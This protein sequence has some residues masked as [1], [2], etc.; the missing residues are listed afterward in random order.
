MRILITMYDEKSIEAPSGG[1]VIVLSEDDTI[2]PQYKNLG[3][4]R[5]IH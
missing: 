5:V 4:F 1:I 3:S 2:N